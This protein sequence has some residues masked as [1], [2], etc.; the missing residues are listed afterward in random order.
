MNA[1]NTLPAIEH[2][3]VA[4][5]LR[6]LERLWDSLQADEAHLPVP[7]WH[8]QGLAAWREAYERDGVSLS[9]DAVEKSLS[10]ALRRR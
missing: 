3:T 8:R 6:L 2:L 1:Q 7:D 10:D 4:E 9:V 5:R